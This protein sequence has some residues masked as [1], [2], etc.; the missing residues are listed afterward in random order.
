MTSLLVPHAGAS[1]ALVRHEL[2]REL[3]GAGLPGD[4]VDDAVLVMSELVGN[5]VRHGRPLPDSQDAVRASW[6]VESGAVHV[7]VC[8]GGPGL[9]GSWPAAQPPSPTADAHLPSPTAEGGRGLPIID[10][11]STRWG[12]TGPS[13]AGAVTVYAELLLGPGPGAG[14]SGDG[15]APAAASP[16]SL[17]TAT[18][19]GP[20][21]A[22]G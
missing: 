7:E 5:A 11:L 12:A 20:H 6:W 9:P 2:V 3:R 22:T 17:P 4:V 18:L 13:P 8:D 1:A 14:T 16:W 19:R 15:Q 21:A 10:L